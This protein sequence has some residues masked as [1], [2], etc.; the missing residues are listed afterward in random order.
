[1]VRSEADFLLA[2]Q[3]NPLNIIK[4][5]IFSSRSLRLFADLLP[6]SH[7]LR[8]SD[9]EIE[10]SCAHL[11]KLLLLLLLLSEERERIRKIE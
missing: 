5:S 9:G 4:S 2:A 1:M 3:P 6:I 8:E 10:F 7:I 11:I